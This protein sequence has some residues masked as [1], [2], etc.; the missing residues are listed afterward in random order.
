MT[1]WLPKDAWVPVTAP[2]INHADERSAKALLEV[3]AQF[4]VATEPRYQRNA[5]GY[6]M[7][8]IYLWDCTR[9]LDAEIPH[10]VYDSGD[11]APMGAPKSRELSANGVCD[12]LAIHGPRFG[13]HSC[14]E[15]AA[16]TAADL[17]QPTSATWRAPPGR[18]GHV[19]V[20]LPERLAAQAGA[21][22]FFGK[23]LRAGFGD[24][25]VKFFTHT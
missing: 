21:S 12:W 23:P 19:A 1:P 14:N 25:P 5:A 13:W 9:A 8:N 16:F 22:N 4:H 24:L 11:R 7:C 18:I 10:W 3:C 17:G 20:V 15:T 2:T 6:T